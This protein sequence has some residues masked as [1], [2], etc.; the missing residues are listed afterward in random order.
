M[1]PQKKRPAS[2]TVIRML[3]NPAADRRNRV[4]ENKLSDNI[5]ELHL[6]YARI[7]ANHCRTKM[8]LQQ[9]L[10]VMREQMEKQ[11]HETY[12][13]IRTSPVAWSPRSIPTMQ[14]DKNTS[15]KGA[16]DELE[17]SDGKN[18]T[19]AK[20]R[21]R[22]PRSSHEERATEQRMNNIHKRFAMQANSRSSIQEIQRQHKM[23]AKGERGSVS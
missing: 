3:K 19:D 13:S 2:S 12:E 16:I 21:K 7:S 20:R 17:A 10:R 1:D 5:Q 8:M 11:S 4:A 22:I 9:E 18:E 23:S 15:Q 6:E 14:Y